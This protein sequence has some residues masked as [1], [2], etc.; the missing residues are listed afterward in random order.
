MSTI[1]IILVFITITV[2]ITRPLSIILHELGHAIAAMALTRQPVSIYIGSTGDPNNSWNIRVGIL[3]AWFTKNP[4]FWII[5][6]GLCVPSAKRFPINKQIIYV[7][8]GPFASLIIASIA[9]YFVFVFDAHVLIK[10]MLIIFLLSAI[11][12][13]Y[14]NLDPDAKPI[15]LYNGKGIY[16]DGQKLKILFQYRKYAKEY[17]QAVELYNQ[18]DYNEASAILQTILQRGHNEV[19]IFKLIIS[20]LYYSKNCLKAKEISDQYFL[21]NNPDSDDYAMAGLIYSLLGHSDQALEFYDKSL[22]QNPTN[23]YALNNKG[24]VLNLHNRFD[25]AIVLFDR[26]LDLDA[27]SADALS[28]R[29]LAKTKL[30]NVSGGL[31][32][33]LNA[34]RIDDK[35]PYG[36]RNLGIY[37]FDH[38]EYAKAVELFTKAKELDYS[39]YE[40]D[41]IL[42]EAVNRMTHQQT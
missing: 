32:D 36:Y 29:G 6:P 40:I 11:L 8:S 27:N 35:I 37:Y 31:E 13:L 22:L 19:Q 7:L 16:N 21:N 12:D 14:I 1:L 39:I 24:F 18:K 42:S 38:G 34:L 15:F 26:V 9:C 17:D 30:G 28:N 33:M 4:L 41:Q 23:F 2:M 3:D 25:E 5:R 10:I 20:S